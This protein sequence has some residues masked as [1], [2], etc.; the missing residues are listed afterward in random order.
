MELPVA[1]GH[2]NH[3]GRLDIY[4]PTTAGA[5]IGEMQY[6]VSDSNHRNRFDGYAKSVA[7]PAAIVWVAESFR[8]KDIKAV[9]ASKVPVVCV[10][11]ALTSDGEVRLVAIGGARLSAQSLEKRVA[12]ANKQAWE[13]V[14]A[15]DWME[16]LGAFPSFVDTEEDRLAYRSISDFD[17]IEE[18]ICPRLFAGTEPAGKKREDI[19]RSCSASNELFDY[20]N[21]FMPLVREH[22]ESWTTERIKDRAEKEARYI[23]RQQRLEVARSKEEEKKRQERESQQKDA[24]L[25]SIKQEAL[26]AYCDWLGNESKSNL[27]ATGH[28]YNKALEACQKRGYD[29]LLGLPC[30]DRFL[31][32]VA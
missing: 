17:W 29:H 12:S 24:V 25:E 16:E 7:N 10:K 31:A 15:V 23:A 28:A 20:I 2:K 11:A 1:K 30:V 21:S 18:T 26:D 14:K 22:F 5:V 9:A 4:Q 3:G 27:L 13:W 8:D 19:I 32:V 6:G